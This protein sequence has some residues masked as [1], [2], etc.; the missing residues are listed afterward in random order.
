MFWQNTLLIPKEVYNRKE[1]NS[2][3]FPRN[4]VLWNEN[5]EPMF[6]EAIAES[7]AVRQ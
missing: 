1:K 6:Q 3:S 4:I 5:A 7:N 2:N